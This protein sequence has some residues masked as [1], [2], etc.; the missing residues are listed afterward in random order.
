MDI[1]MEQLIADYNTIKKFPEESYEDVYHK[2]TLRSVSRNG[3]LKKVD[4]ADEKCRYICEG[5]VGLF[6]EMQDGLKLFRIFGPSDVA[7]DEQSFRTKTPSKTVLK[8][9]SDTVFL[10][11]SLFSGIPE[12]VILKYMI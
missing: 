7:F 6:Q 10:D 9:L 11:F 12:E 5:Y 3:I 1:Y 4:M 2:L 8:A